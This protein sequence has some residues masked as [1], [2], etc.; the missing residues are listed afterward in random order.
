ME[1][2]SE[3][4]D[5]DLWFMFIDYAKAFDTVS[6]RALWRALYDLGVPKHLI[7]I[8]R[9]LYSN[10]RGTVRIEDQHTDEFRFEKEVVRD[11]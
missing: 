4:A 8:V 1:K 2:A 3:K 11:V 5:V 7:R 10:A 9:G 6:H